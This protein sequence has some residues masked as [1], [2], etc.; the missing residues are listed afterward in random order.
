MWGLK[1]NQKKLA[2]YAIDY[3][4]RWFLMELKRLFQGISY[5]DSE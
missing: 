4:F 5:A 1:F 3:G 2:F